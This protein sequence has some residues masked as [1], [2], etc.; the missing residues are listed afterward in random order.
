MSSEYGKALKI[1]VFGQSHGKAIGVNIDGLPSGEQIDL[2]ELYAF[3]ARRAPGKNEF[4]TKRSEADMPVFLSGIE[5][6]KT[7]GF[8]VCA[9]IENKDT[10]STDYAGLSRTPRPSHADYTALL[11]YGESV[12]LRGGGH[13]SGRLTAPL[14]IAGGI[15]KQIL[16]RRGIFIGA[17]LSSVGT[18]KDEKFPLYPTKEL[19]DEVAKKE[20]PVIN[21]ELE[22]KMADQ[23][24]EAAAEAD[25]VGATIECAITGFPAGIG[26]PMFDG[27]ENRM[28]QAIFGISAVKGIEFGAG[29]ESSEM[30]GSKNNDPFRI[31][32][33]KIVT[34]T[35]NCGGILGG[36]SNGMPIVFRAAFK[37]TPSI[38][39]EQKTV[40]VKTMENTTVTVKGRHDPCVAVRAVPVVEAVAATVILD[41]LLEESEVI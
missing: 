24:R 33:E 31:E 34:E 21:D 14:C 9:I 13:F 26:S 17:H 19:F 40:D 8:P 32:N 2:E 10:R 35:N 25:S 41:M 38:G 30:R 22:K 36:I 12:D 29:F 4:A 39:I 7:C 3:M 23:I 37:P 28:A 11:R 27:I 18:A 1:S 20:L 15:A 6:N 5:N 16:A